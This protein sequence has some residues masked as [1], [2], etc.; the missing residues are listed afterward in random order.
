MEPV[1]LDPDLFIAHL[2]SFY[3]PL[4]AFLSFLATCVPVTVGLKDHKSAN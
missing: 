4:T 3:S 2:G 1:L